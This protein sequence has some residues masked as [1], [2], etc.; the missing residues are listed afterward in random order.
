MD[1]IHHVLPECGGSSQKGFI[2]TA[3][4]A[5]QDCLQKWS[6]HP[7][8]MPLR[9]EH[10]AQLESHL[11]LLHVPTSLGNGLFEPRNSVTGRESSSV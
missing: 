10:L 6:S 3:C 11:P 2:P 7:C 4:P 8:C 5:F 1:D 9:P